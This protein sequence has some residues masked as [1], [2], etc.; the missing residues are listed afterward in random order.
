[1]NR[2]EARNDG[3]NVSI[4]GMPEAARAAAREADAALASNRDLGSLH[5]VP[6]ASMNSTA[7]A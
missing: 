2:I 3:I 1:L 4:T 5:G 6:I 7:A